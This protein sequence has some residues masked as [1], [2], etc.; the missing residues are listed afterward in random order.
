MAQQGINLQDLQRLLKK[1]GSRWEARET[2]LTHLAPDAQQRRLGF[3][4]HIP[5]PDRERLALRH[6]ETDA[7]E[8]RPRTYPATFDWRSEQGQSYTTLVRDQGDCGS[9]VAFATVASIEAMARIEDRNPNL[10]IDLSEA[11]LFYCIAANEGCTCDSGWSIAAACEAVQKIGLICEESYPYVAGNQSQ[12]CPPGA[13]NW[14]QQPNVQIVSWHSIQSISEM[15]MWVAAHGPLTVGFSVYEDFI[16]YASGIYHH[17]HGNLLGGHA[18]S[19]VGYDDTQRCWICKNSW[20]S[21]WG[22]QGF[23]RIAYGQCGID[24]EA[25]AIQH[26]RQNQ[27]QPQTAAA[28][29]AAQPANVVR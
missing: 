14:Q 24:A 3:I 16:S 29:A 27:P 1:S 4:P 20:G 25:W 5:L 28:A 9:C 22:E 21:G 18:V 7:L 17:V 12:P 26:V 13:L 10:M 6:H 23:F 8:M 19:I 2:P 15:K 11:Q